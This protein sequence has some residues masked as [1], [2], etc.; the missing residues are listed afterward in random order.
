[1][2]DRL[3]THTGC[4][5]SAKVLSVHLLGIT[6]FNTCLN[7]QR[8]LAFELGERKDRHA[9]LLLCEHPPIITVGRRGSRG[10]ILCDEQELNSRQLPVQWINRGGGTIVH[11]PGQLAVYPIVPLKRQGWGL[12]EFTERIRQSL[13]DLVQEFKIPTTH[14]NQNTVIEGRHGP[15]VFMGFSVQDWISYHGCYVNV[16]PDMFLQK[17]TKPLGQQDSLQPRI[18]SMASEKV[19]QI[20]MDSVRESIIRHI[21]YHLNFPDCHLYS[22]HSLLRST[23]SQAA[24]VRQTG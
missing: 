12:S 23:P 3:L 18:S 6:D 11:A 8:R 21:Q 5:S 17:L 20:R 24:P 4:E 10:D 9:H 13:L 2:A 19:R 16:M 22:G 14:A 7:L 15:L 1:M